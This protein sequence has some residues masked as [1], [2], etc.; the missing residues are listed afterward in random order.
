VSAVAPLAV[1]FGSVLARRMEAR[2]HRLQRTAYRL[3]A[4]LYA[5]K[6][7]AH[8]RRLARYWTVAQREG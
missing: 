6:P 5:E 8:V 1:G 3:G 2:R 7:G 4:R